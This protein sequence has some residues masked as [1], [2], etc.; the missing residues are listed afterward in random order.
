M[1][2]F[3]MSIAKQFE[4]FL[5]ATCSTGAKAQH[6]EPHIWMGVPEKACIS[7]FQVFSSTSIGPKWAIPPQ[8][9]SVMRTG[10]TIHFE[11][12]LTLAIKSKCSGVNED[13]VCIRVILIAASVQI[14]SIFMSTCT[15]AT[16]LNQI[17]PASSRNEE[18]MEPRN[19]GESNGNRAEPCIAEH[20]IPPQD[21]DDRA[22]GAGPGAREGRL[23]LCRGFPESMGD[24]LWSELLGSSNTWGAIGLYHILPTTSAFPF[25]LPFP[26]SLIECQNDGRF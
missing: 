23:G 12:G 2:S 25:Y 6:F 4:S 7:I 21:Q 26:G 1:T 17:P 24:R 20:Y 14:P 19:I 10:P 16:M 11:W 13:K 9:A 3:S 5:S 18:V 15:N 8:K 22:E